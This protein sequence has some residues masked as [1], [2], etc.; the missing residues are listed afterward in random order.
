MKVT[1]KKQKKRVV[2]THKNL[3]L[4]SPKWKKVPGKNNKELVLKVNGITVGQAYFRSTGE[5]LVRARFSTLKNFASSW[6]LKPTE[7]REEAEIHTL[8]KTLMDQV[9]DK[10]FDK[11]IVIYEGEE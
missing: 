8:W 3:R 6:I 11:F 10:V 9:L 4:L 2:P 7:G 5:I 1:V